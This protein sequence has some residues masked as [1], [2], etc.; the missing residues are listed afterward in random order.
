MLWVN[1]GEGTSKTWGAVYAE[2]IEIGLVKGPKRYT[3]DVVPY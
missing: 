2:H 3:L 1:Y